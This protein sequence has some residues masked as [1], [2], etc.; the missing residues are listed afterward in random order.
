MQDNLN[1]S[2]ELTKTQDFN[3]KPPLPQNFCDSNNPKNIISYPRQRKQISRSASISILN[4][5]PQPPLPHPDTCQDQ[6]DF[7]YG[8]RSMP[9][10]PH[11][12]PMEAEA[13]YS[14]AT[15][16]PSQVKI[17]RHWTQV[18][19]S[20]FKTNWFEALDTE[21]DS[22]FK[23]DAFKEVTPEDPEL[24]QYLLDGHRIL[25]SIMIWSVK[26]CKEG[27]VSRFK[28]RVCARGD[29]RQVGIHHASAEVYA[30]I[31]KLKSLRIL[32]SVTLQDVFTI[33]T[34]HWDIQCAF[35][36]GL[37]NKLVCS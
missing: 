21:A 37:L 35:L 22:F 34:D 11:S 17:P 33:S 30:N 28:C 20:P 13:Y 6:P 18:L 31:L 10:S 19:L 26:T 25:E 4:S 27:L 15:L 1:S 7:S 8:T 36:A 14:S 24:K 5:L 23:L 32:F 12:P 9:P 16:R 2:M 3:V 29:T